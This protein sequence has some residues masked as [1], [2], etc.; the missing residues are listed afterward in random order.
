MPDWIRDVLRVVLLF[1]F[2]LTTLAAAIWTYAI[3]TFGEA[4][5]ASQTGLAY[6]L[7]LLAGLALVGLWML[8]PRR[9]S[10]D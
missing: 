3:S 2:P 8:R 6:G 7:W 9:P 5:L 10:S 4:P 1:A